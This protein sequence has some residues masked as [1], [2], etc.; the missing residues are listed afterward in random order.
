MSGIP[1]WLQTQMGATKRGAGLPLSTM[2]WKLRGGGVRGSNGQRDEE[3]SHPSEKR[4]ARTKYGM[5]ASCTLRRH[6]LRGYGQSGRS[7]VPRGQPADV[8][9]ATTHERNTVRSE[10]RRSGLA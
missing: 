8:I 10:R 1:W 2:R 5:V 3:R 7:P 9:F 4:F 6:P